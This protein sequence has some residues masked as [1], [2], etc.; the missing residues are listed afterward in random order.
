MMAT[1]RSG[2]A[3]RRREQLTRTT[4]GERRGRASEKRAS[5]RMG[6]EEYNAPGAA[7]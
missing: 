7:M 6:P 3:M 5:A 1:E 2:T 4:S